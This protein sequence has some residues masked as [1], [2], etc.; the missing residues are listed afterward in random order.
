VEEDHLGKGD[1]VRRAHGEKEM[2]RL[3]L[4]ILFVLIVCDFAMAENCGPRCTGTR[5]VP[6]INGEPVEAGDL[7]QIECQMFLDE[8]DRQTPAFSRLE[9]IEEP[10][11]RIDL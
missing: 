4:L 7:D 1:Q 5:F 2:I 9:C 3:A 8:L 11:A 6:H 10:I